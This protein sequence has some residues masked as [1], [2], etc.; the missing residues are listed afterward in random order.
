MDPMPKNGQNAQN[1]QSGHSNNG[2]SATAAIKNE[3]KPRSDPVIS[4]PENQPSLD[5]VDKSMKEINPFNSDLSPTSCREMQNV[6]LPQVI[7]GTNNTSLPTQL[8]IFPEKMFLQQ[9]PSKE[10]I[11]SLDE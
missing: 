7:G 5:D 9:T 4:I 2:V 10:E 3:I 1:G 11:L 8:K 6:P